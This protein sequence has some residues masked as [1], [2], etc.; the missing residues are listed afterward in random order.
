[1]SLNRAKA[2]KASSAIAAATPSIRGPLHPLE[3]F[4][5]AVLEQTPTP[6]TLALIVRVGEAEM[7]EIWSFVQSKGQPRW[8]WHAI[9]HLTG[10]VLAYVLEPHKDA[11]LLAIIAIAWAR[12]ASGC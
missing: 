2:T 9:D 3:P 5:R 4:N 1:M 8:L 10:V 7:D 11:T 6:A 12:T